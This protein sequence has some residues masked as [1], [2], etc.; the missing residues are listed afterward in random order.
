MKHLQDWAAEWLRSPQYATEKHWS[1]VFNHTLESC[2]TIHIKPLARACNE[3]RVSLAK[4]QL[5]LV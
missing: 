4:H 1:L 3:F 2:Q 5:F